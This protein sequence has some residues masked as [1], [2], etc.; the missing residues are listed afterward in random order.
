MSGKSKT[1]R[2]RTNLWRQNPHCRC[3]GVET[4]LPRHVLVEREDGR[5][6][7]PN[8]IP[9]NLATL[10]HHD[11]RY[12]PH[13]GVDG[14]GYERTTLYCRRCNQRESDLRQRMIPKVIKRAKSRL[15]HLKKRKKRED[16]TS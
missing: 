9:E 16:S 2:R 11:D 12:S 5:K 4:V 7:F 3:C 14:I 8:G 6:V 10:Q 13:R 15:G 1:R